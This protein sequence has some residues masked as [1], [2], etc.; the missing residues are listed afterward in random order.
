M[1]IRPPPSTYFN[2]TV[3]SNK[4]PQ[5]HKMHTNNRC[6]ICRAG[7]NSIANDCAFILFCRSCCR[8]ASKC[9]AV[10]ASNVRLWLG[11]CWHKA[12]SSSCCCW[13]AGNEAASSKRIDK[14]VVKIGSGISLR[15]KT[16]WLI[17]MGKNT[18]ASA[19]LKNNFNKLQAMGTSNSS[20]SPPSRL[21]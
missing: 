15:K 3:S 14:S 18:Q 4:L 8:T 17:K 6:D 1:R 5:W 21:L 12:I 11:N 20:P 2:S 16:T 10:H 19:Y 13:T 7:L 9:L